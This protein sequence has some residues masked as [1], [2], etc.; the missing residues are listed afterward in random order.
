M[1]KND[2]RQELSNKLSA[3]P[4]WEIDKS[5][6]YFSELI[7]D[8]IED[9]MNE[10]EAV[11]SLESIDDIAQKIML[12]MPLSALVKARMKPKKQLSALAIVLIV[13][14]FPVW[15]PILISIF[16]IVFSVYVSIW[17]I[18]ISMFAAIFAFVVSGL[19]VL[20]TSPFAFSGG[21][22]AGLFAIG[23]GF[24]YLGVSIMIFFP[25]RF[26]SK[27]LIRLTKWVLLKIKGLFI[28]KEV[29]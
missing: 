29:D 20:V 3:Y 10:E 6:S 9:G 7:D 5:L 13:L 25:I 1:N 17:A 14:G 15:F 18:I 4:Q 2:F 21:T 23:Q 11:A 12:E 8:R 28:Q 24:I 26:I 16:A 22:A 27:Q 19:A